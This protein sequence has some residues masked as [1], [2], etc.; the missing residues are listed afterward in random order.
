MNTPND[1][2]RD[3]VFL[4]EL[5]KPD[6]SL[7]DKL[8]VASAVSGFVGLV[9]IPLSLPFVA[10]LAAFGAIGLGI[11]GLKSRWQRWAIVGIV[12]GCLILLLIAAA[13]AL[14]VL[15]FQRY[16]ASFL[17]QPSPQVANPSLASFGFDALATEFVVEQTDQ[18]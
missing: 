5:A 4:A 10:I 12:C 16:E 2:E 9:S 17:F 6:A 18:A 7:G 11:A 3:T 1:L 14:S 15:E 8:A 13:I